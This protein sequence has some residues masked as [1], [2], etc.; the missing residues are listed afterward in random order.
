[1]SGEI[2]SFLLGSFVSGGLSTVA[3][4]IA[5]DEHDDTLLGATI[6]MSIASAIALNSIKEL[7]SSD[8][9]EKYVESLSEEQLAELSE[10]LEAKE[11]NFVVETNANNKDI[12]VKV[13]TN[14]S[15]RV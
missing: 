2:I 1:M 4:C 15:K 7:K 5:Q 10:K 12:V 11:K 14:S 6:T 3:S 8:I 9:M 13:K